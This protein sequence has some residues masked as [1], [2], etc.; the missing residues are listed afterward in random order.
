[1][2]VRLLPDAPLLYIARI[3]RKVQL[4]V[5]APSEVAIMHEPQVGDIYYS[6]MS[7]AHFL[8]IKIVPRRRWAHRVFVLW[9]DNNWGEDESD[10]DIFRRTEHHRW[11]A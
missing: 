1:M 4:K 7:Q 10:M 5:N 8:I 11:V 6:E 9:L 3:G 2:Q